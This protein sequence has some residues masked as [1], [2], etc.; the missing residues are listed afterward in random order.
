MSEKG[1]AGGMGR[2]AL[3]FL[4][5]S[6]LTLIAAA[7]QDIEML[8]YQPDA[9]FY[10]R[11]AEAGPDG[12]LLPFGRRVL[13]P[14]TVRLFSGIAGIHASF[15]AVGT[16]CYF[17]FLFIVFQQLFQRIRFPILLSILLTAVPATFGIYKYLYLPHAF[18]LALTAIFFILLLAGRFFTA[19]PVLFAV[20]LTR[21][22]GIILAAAFAAAIFFS[23]KSMKSPVSRCF[24][25]LADAASVIAA[26]AILRHM[27]PGAD[28]I[29]EMSRPVFLVGKVSYYFLR[30]VFGIVLWADTWKDLD[31]Y[32][33]APLWS[34][35]VP[36]WLAAVSSVREI[37]L[38][39]F[40]PKEAFLVW[41]KMLTLF[42]TAPAVIA[43]FLRKGIFRFAEFSPASLVILF[44]SIAL[45]M[46][47]PFVGT[48]TEAYIYMSWGLIFL[49]MPQAL[50]RAAECRPLL[51][52]EVLAVYVLT[53]WIPYLFS[54][55]WAEDS[56]IY[57]FVVLAGAFVLNGFCF[58]R[59]NLT[60]R[61]KKGVT[62]I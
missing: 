31:F 34:R 55:L 20:L 30:N 62:P 29:H 10:Y 22:E 24:L 39:A 23:G 25:L 8:R 42:G 38:Y 7:G 13:Y 26:S 49:I 11:M 27:N 5:A 52:Y 48:A 60:G 54:K 9:E 43:A 40:Q 57:C 44:Y 21:D 33:Q 14:L 18:S 6:L 45:F 41:I 50:L 2:T 37:G 12:V 4:T 58:V 1:I 47:A 59:V 51:V 56:W 35:P 28:N 36:Q 17:L 46:L 3:A 19:M 16:A 61:G 15:F 32:A 53:A